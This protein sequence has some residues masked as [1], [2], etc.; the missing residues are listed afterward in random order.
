MVRF[1]WLGAF[2]QQGG[3]WTG[4]EV[5][6]SYSNNGVGFEKTD[7]LSDEIIKYVEDKLN[8]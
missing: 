7:L 3:D 8:K 5:R 6:Y 1:A 4:G 2:K